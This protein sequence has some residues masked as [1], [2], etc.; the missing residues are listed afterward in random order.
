[1]TTLSERLSDAKE[2]DDRLQ[3]LVFCYIKSIQRA[4]KSLP[5]VPTE[6]FYLCILFL[7]Q[8]EC[9]H[10][11][12][13]DI[14]LSLDKLTITKNKTAGTNWLNTSYGKVVIASTSKSIAIWKIKIHKSERD[15]NKCIGITSSTKCVNKDFSYGQDGYFYVFSDNGCRF[16]SDIDEDA[17]KEHNELFDFHSFKYKSDDTLIIKLDLKAATIS[18][19]ADENLKIAWTNIKIDKNVSY[20][21]GASLR[22]P[23]DSISILDFVQRN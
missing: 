9:F 16:K 21:F 2:A 3:K 8:R 19:G 13:S 12:P 6:I 20:R 17:S 4:N 18:F 15:C 7:F 23:R 11:I 22:F 1:M 5:I 10:I 14:F